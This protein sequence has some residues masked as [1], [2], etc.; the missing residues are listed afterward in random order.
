MQNN[1]ILAVAIAS[2]LSVSSGVAYG[3]FENARDGMSPEA[4]NFVYN[5]R[6]PVESFDFATSHTVVRV[7]DASGTSGT[8][9][10]SELFGDS[11]T[12]PSGDTSK[13]TYAAVVY[14]V[15][16]T[17]SDNFEMT[18]TLTNGA[19]FAAEPLLGIADGTAST[20]AANVAT[21]AQAGTNN[22]TI[23]ENTTFPAADAI[24]RF[25]GHETMYKVTAMS[26]DSG[27]HYME[28]MQVGTDSDPKGLTDAV[29]SSDKIYLYSEGDKIANG[30]NVVDVDG[31][32]G[33]SIATTEAQPPQNGNNSVANIAAGFSNIIEGAYYRFHGDPD[34]SYQVVAAN[35]DVCQDNCI[36]VASNYPQ[37]S[38]FPV[39]QTL[40]RV[41]QTGDIQ[42]HVGNA[43]MLVKDDV[44]LIGS[45]YY[46]ITDINT[47]NGSN[48]ITIKE[49]GKTTGLAEAL[50][51]NGIPLYNKKAFN[52]SSS[53]GDEWNINNTDCKAKITSKTGNTDGLP[54]KPKTNTGQGKSTA[55]F[56][57]PAG[58]TCSG[59]NL[60]LIGG[61]K[62]MLLYRLDNT[63]V[64][65]S[66][67]Q[68]IT[69]Q[70]S[71]QTDLTNI[72]V[73]PA[74]EIT[75]ASS[76]PAIKTFDIKPLEGGDIKISV[77]SD[78]KEFTG[79]GDPFE[80]ATEAIIGQISLDND[81]SSPE[82]KAADGET[83][84]EIGKT[85]ALADKST[86]QITDGQ[87]AAS[88]K[89]PGSVFL[90]ASSTNLTAD[91]VTETDATWN[92]HDT[93]LQ[94]IETAGVD[95]TGIHFKLDGQTAVN[96]PEN[97]PHA[98]LTIDFDDTKM[99]DMTVEADLRKIKKD[100]TICQ[101]YNV[102]NTAATD[103]LSIRITNDSAV[104]G[105]LT[106]ALYNM[107]G[108]EAIAA[109]T[110]LFEGEEIQPG[111][112][113]RLSA[114]DLETLAGA[115]WTGRARAVI[116]STLPKLAVLSLLRQNVAGGALVNMSTGAKGNSCGN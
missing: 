26:T 110:E 51:S 18:F 96:V 78:S 62:L 73:N 93:G 116:S 108:T 92:L 83:K 72:K 19:T 76:K 42:L 74:R 40:T 112:T 11:R 109:G 12:L 99:T 107:D 27:T 91:T 115:A 10:A 25:S 82:V 37:D 4:L 94:S 65:A 111:E 90:K 48:V 38:N 89:S 53:T 63:K 52:I 86:L 30:A 114:G 87:F 33:T 105:K 13:G 88:L 81:E 50:T 84:F 5:P 79:E 7:N 113:R 21:G 101:V 103:A 67:G 2:T 68:K 75:V 43:A 22:V 3:S 32:L 36:K 6:I 56:V 28:F 1:R 66:P 95:G 60:N 20:A 23:D 39:S 35:S 80:G 70:V 64:L 106:I 98:I 17:I 47:T 15:D 59:G 14:T 104:A 29:A 24:F 8:V 85:G 100:G 45:K 41:Y 16:G 31:G 71:L 58:E 69:M 77:L 44:Y 57:I 97:N 49:E 9:Y 55:T 34:N 54:L 46:Q 102:P 61:D